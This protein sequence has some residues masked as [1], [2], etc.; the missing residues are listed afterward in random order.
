VKHAATVI[1]STPLLGDYVRLRNRN[2]VQLDSFFDFSLIPKLPAARARQGP[3]RGGFAASADRVLDLTPV[4]EDVISMLDEHA[5]L[6]F[7]VIGAD[8]NDLPRHPRLRSFGYRASYQEYIAFQRSRHWD[9]AL[10]PLGSAPS[11]LYKTDNK[12]REYAAQG[13]PGIYEDAPPYYS[14]RDE[15]T[16]LLAGKSR[17]WR[18]A[19]TRYV[20][21]PA[22]RSR[23]RR[24][25]RV[26]AENRCALENVAPEWG[27]F[28]ESAP[29]VGGSE[30][31]VD[32]VRRDFSLHWSKPARAVSR[33]QLLFA[34]GRKHLADE[35]FVAT[36][37][38]TARFLRKRMP[39]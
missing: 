19:L 15:E 29:S 7:E 37:A 30:E 25:A 10:A 2:V 31:R 36:A 39:W 27:S 3:V 13:I 24:A 12:F 28:F 11:N 26:D 9:F 14:V 8:D 20:D 1:V 32:R 34:Y 23:V 18:E 17:S 5:D 4:L 38:Q 22:L 35:G 21:D 33:G 16:G 6:E